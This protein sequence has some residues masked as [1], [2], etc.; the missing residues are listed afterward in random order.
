MART[1]WEYLTQPVDGGYKPEAMGNSTKLP[2]HDGKEL[3]SLRDK[4]W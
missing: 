4:K 2:L 1:L 3:Y